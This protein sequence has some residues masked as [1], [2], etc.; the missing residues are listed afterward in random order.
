M[1]NSKR[2]VLKTKIKTEYAKDNCS[3]LLKSIIKQSFIDGNTEM[4]KT[5][6]DEDLEFAMAGFTHKVEVLGSTNGGHTRCHLPIDIEHTDN[7]KEYL[8]A[9]FVGH[10]YDAI[11]WKLFELKLG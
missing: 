3:E 7:I 1:A 2:T 5:L 9:R 10:N 8:R 4:G 11:A 6:E